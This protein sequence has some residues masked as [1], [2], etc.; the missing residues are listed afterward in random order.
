MACFISYTAA[1]VA[2]L[3]LSAALG[4][5]IESFHLTDAQGGLFQTVF[6]LVY[7]VGQ[8]VNGSIVDRISARGYITAGLILSGVCNLLFGLSRSYWAMV[9]FWALNGAVQ[10]MLWTPIVKVMAV[11][12]K[13]PRR[14]RASFGISM[15]LVLGNVSAWAL[16][17][18]MAARVGWRLSFVIPAAVVA[19]A[20]AAAWI[21]LRDKPAPG[22]DVGEE[23]AA[24]HTDDVG[25]AMPVG[26]MIMKTGLVM[27]L[28]CCACNGFVR[29]GIITWGPTILASLGGGQ[30][31]GS[32]LSSLLIPLLN[33]IG[34]LMARRVYGLF[35]SSARRSVAYLMGASAALALALHLASGMLVSCALVLGLCCSAT[36]GINPML[37]QLIPMEYERVGRVGLVAGMS[38]CFIYLGSALAG[39]VTG[40]ISDAAGWP[41]VFSLWCAVALM[42]MVFAFLSLRGG[43]RLERGD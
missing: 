42:S 8:L 39:V 17:G 19:A 27:I 25:Q 1:Y 14:A 16:S 5:V 15:T 24:Q 34:V 40:A 38:D 30:G 32:I 37:T 21:M 7:A 35:G 11:W 13:G 43:R 10:S 22:E 4:S 36:Y 33:F 41:V 6:A 29:D 12:F 20:A 3:N 26:G 23:R 9:A 28:L 2:R 18:F 31:T